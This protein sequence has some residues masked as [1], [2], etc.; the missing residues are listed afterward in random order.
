MILELTAVNPLLADSL[1]SL[2]GR[3]GQQLPTKTFDRTDQNEA[4]HELAK[5]TNNSWLLGS[6]QTVRQ[7]RTEQPELENE[8]STPPIRPWISQRA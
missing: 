8:R 2:G 5:N 6:L 1:A 3:S 4:T 7:V